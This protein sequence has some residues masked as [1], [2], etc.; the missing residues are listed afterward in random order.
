MV[1]SRLEKDQR[2]PHGKKRVTDDAYTHVLKLILGREL[3]G[4]SVLQERLLCESLGVSRTPMRET[5]RRLEGEGLISRSADGTLMVRRVSLEEYLNSLE[6]RV[7]VEPHAAFNAA[8]VMP[9]DVLRRLRKSLNAI[10]PQNKPS[11]AAHWKFDDSLHESIG[12]YGGNPLVAQII[13]EMRRLTK[14]FERQEAPDRVAPGW[15]EHDALLA[16][17]EAGHQQRALETM[18]DHLQQVRRGLLNSL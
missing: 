15:A 8:K 7:L 4:G 9:E 6:V 14:M 5:L 2:V 18:A 12:S 17:L 1:V 11:S 16:A 3:P 13:A 10:A